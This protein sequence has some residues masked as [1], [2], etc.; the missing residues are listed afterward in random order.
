MSYLYVTGGQHRK[1]AKLWQEFHRGRKGIIVKIN[2][3]TKQPE[4]CVEYIS[5]SQACADNKPSISFKSGFIDNNELYVCTTT[6]IL[7]YQL[8]NLEQ[9]GYI[10]LPCFN[11]VHHVRPTSE[12]NLLVVNTG[13]DMVVNLTREGKLLQVWNVL[14]K[15]PWQR[16]SREIDYRKLL[17]TKPHQSHPNYTFLL[18]NDIWATRFEQKDC[19]CLTTKNKRIEIGIERPHDGVVN[20]ESIYFTTVDGHLVIVDR[21]TL[22]IKEIIN[23]SSL[24]P[25]NQDQL[26]GWCR[27]IMIDQEK[28]WI[29]FSRIRPTKW[30]ENLSWIKS[31][32]QPSK[33]SKTKPTRIVCYDLREKIYIDEINLENLGLN[34][35]F[36]V[37]LCNG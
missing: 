31:G 9:I 27:G 17:T 11:D 28:A 4:I 33:T 34:A 23:L 25:N 15:E 10:S 26:I 14:G 35:I 16:F 19:I 3:E 18:N 6:E 32:F 30:I 22:K 36:S 5:P 29:G 24:E 2:L 37:L 21:T 12:G 1:N 7:I 8:P 20:N 13:L